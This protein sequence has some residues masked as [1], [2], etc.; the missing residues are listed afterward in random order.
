MRERAKALVR[1]AR[2]AQTHVVLC[3]PATLPVAV[4]ATLYA[5]T[6][7]EY[8]LCVRLGRNHPKCHDLRT[9]A[10]EI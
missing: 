6:E 7:Y 9:R 4:V 10:M 3:T 2:Q 5:W 1:R 8:H